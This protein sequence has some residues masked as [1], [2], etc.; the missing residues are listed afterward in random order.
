MRGVSAAFRQQLIRDVLCMWG[1]LPH[2]RL[3]AANRV[4]HALQHKPILVGPDDEQA[5]SLDMELL[6]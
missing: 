2:Q 1:I 4:V 3:C 6:P 5:T